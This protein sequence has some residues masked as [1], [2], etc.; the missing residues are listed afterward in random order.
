MHSEQKGRYPKCGLRK[1]NVGER[2]SAE[3]Q[4]AGS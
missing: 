3:V 2:E 1:R 4:A